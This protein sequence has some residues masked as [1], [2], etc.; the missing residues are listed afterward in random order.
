MG[1]WVTVDSVV[2]DYMGEA[3][4][5][6]S[7]YYKLWQIAFRG[8]E[9]L[10]VDF[11]Y[12]VKTVK[13]PINANGTATLPPNIN[14]I[15]I[16]VF[17]M[18][19]GF[20]PLSYNPKLTTYASLNTNRESRNN[21]N[22]GLINNLDSIYSIS[23]PCFYNYYGGGYLYG[24]TWYGGSFNVDEK[25]GIVLFDNWTS[26]TDVA[27]EVMCAPTAGEEYYI[28]SVFREALIEWIGWR[29]IKHLP[30]SRRSNIGEKRDRKHDYYNAR[31]LAGT[32]FKPFN[33]EQAAMT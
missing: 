33:L 10:G 19:G 28:P 3:E 6:V 8:M 22:G 31:R 7:Q 21:V 20:I 32:R 26:I 16:G 12:E 17:D 11:F 9:N 13:I 24:D 14:W 29:D 5:S 25:N 2:N 23:S 30:N 27:V 4:L 18:L 1:D 15:K